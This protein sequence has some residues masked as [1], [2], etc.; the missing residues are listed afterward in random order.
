MKVGAMSDLRRLVLAMVVLCGTMFGTDT[1]QAACV[2]SP[3]CADCVGCQQQYQTMTACDACYIGVRTSDSEP[4]QCTFLGVNA[5][6]SPMSPLTSPPSSSPA[7][8]RLG[9]PRVLP[10]PRPI[11]GTRP[12]S[13]WMDPISW[14]DS[15]SVTRSL[16]DLYDI[17]ADV[18]PDWAGSSTTAGTLPGTRPD[19]LRPMSKAARLWQ[20]SP[21]LLASSITDTLPISAWL[22]LPGTRPERIRPTADY[23]RRLEAGSMLTGDAYSIDGRVQLRTGRIDPH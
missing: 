19:T 15:L 13:V 22:T 14:P 11:P 4:F 23:L 7:G 8:P 3:T 12:N 17:R 2:C 21:D 20:M 1:T 5:P 9:T 16:S 18:S 6:L 10:A